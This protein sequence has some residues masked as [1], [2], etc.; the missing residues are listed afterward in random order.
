MDIDYII[1]RCAS[2]RFLPDVAGQ[3]V[4][5]YN[6]IFMT[7]QEFKKLKLPHGQ[8]HAPAAADHFP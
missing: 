1:E 4:S 2:S 7:Q 8:L 3:R 5:R 6:L